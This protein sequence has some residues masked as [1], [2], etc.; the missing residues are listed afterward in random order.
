MIELPDLPRLTALNHRETSPA[1]A[2]YNCIAWAANDASRWWE[3]GCYWTI[4]GDRL[5]S[6]PANLVA[7]FESI[8][9]VRCN[10]AAQESNWEKVALY[11]CGGEYTHAARQLESGK[12]TSKLGAHLD[13][14]HD[15]PD[16]VGG[17]VYGEVFAFLKRPITP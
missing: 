2:A 17:G 8:G 5:E 13:I 12:W 1:T 6:G 15:S 14:E 11:S 9:F 4:P 16:D 7:V 3:P 10:S